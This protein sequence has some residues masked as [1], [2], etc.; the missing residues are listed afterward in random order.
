M[1]RPTKYKIQ[2]L[3]IILALSVPAFLLGRS[4]IGNP[5]ILLA[6]I[7]L[8]LVPGRLSGF[9][10]R[11]FYLG[12]RL[13]D[14]GQLRK[15]IEAHRRFILLLEQRPWIQRLWW[16]A[17][18]FYSRS[19]KAMALNNIGSAYLELGEIDEARK[20]FLDAIAIDPGYAIPH[21]NMAVLTTVT[22]A[23]AEAKSYAD[24]AIELGYSDD[25]SDRIAAAGASLVASIEGRGP[26]LPGGNADA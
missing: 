9:F 15:S 19:P 6:A 20:A 4:L 8:F 2:Y 26:R 25:V 17:W 7:I 11:D 21:F 5:L 18:V 10:W 23:D 22:G 14:A 12:R 16:L 1:T 3:V 13:L 24:Q